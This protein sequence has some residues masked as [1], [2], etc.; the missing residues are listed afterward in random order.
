LDKLVQDR[1]PRVFISYAHELETHGEWVLALADRL[2]ADGIDALVDRHVDWPEK[3]WRGWMNEQIECADWLLLVCTAEYR[4]RFDGN[5]P[6]DSGRGVRWESQHITQTLY[7]DKLRNRRFVP[8]LP[9]G[10]QA[11]DIPL[12]LRDWPSFRPERAYEALFR[13]LS[14]Q[15]ETPPRPLG[16]RRQLLPRLVTP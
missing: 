15:P 5:V 2:R 6:G 16:K 3:G 11:E 4:R 10:G 1:P 14:G 9:P 7:D 8:V 13:L 12:P